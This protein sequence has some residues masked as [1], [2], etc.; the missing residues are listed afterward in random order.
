MLDFLGG[1]IDFELIKV[2]ITFFVSIIILRICWNLLR[3]HRIIKVIF[4]GVLL[5]YIVFSIV[6]YANNKNKIYSSD[7]YYV[8]GVIRRIDPNSIEIYST[9]S[10]FEQGGEGTIYVVAKNNTLIVDS[11]N[12]D[13][14][15][16]VRD[17]KEGY[18]IQV[19]T[20]ST[21][22]KNSED[23]VVAKTIIL[24]AIK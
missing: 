4:I 15:I 13:K 12:D 10:N 16:N 19:Y 7:G 24:K 8:Y 9:R 18:T 22:S 20:T 23:S 1:N 3:K 14:I 17:L 5:A 11:N 6:N 2:I 21:T